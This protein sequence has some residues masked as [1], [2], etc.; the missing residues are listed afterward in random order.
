MKLP[1]NIRRDV[2]EMWNHT[3]HS[4]RQTCN[5]QLLR[6]H[7]KGTRSGGNGGG[8]DAHLLETIGNELSYRLSK[9]QYEYTKCGCSECKTNE[10]K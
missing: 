7:G 3:L 9:S 6:L 2:E 5:Q 4:I 8:L 1:E 10:E